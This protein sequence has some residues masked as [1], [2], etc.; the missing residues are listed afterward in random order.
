MTWFRNSLGVAAVPMDTSRAIVRWL[1]L[2]HGTTPVPNVVGDP[3]W[4][5]DR[6]VPI[7]MPSRG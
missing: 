7:L 1:R 3:P 2:P 5:V 4:A 6:F